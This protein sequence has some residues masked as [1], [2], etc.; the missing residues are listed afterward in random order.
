M[1]PDDFLRE[2]ADGK[3]SRGLLPLE[4]PAGSDDCADVNDMDESNGDSI[5]GDGNDPRLR[6]AVGAIPGLVTPG[7]AGSPSYPFGVV[8][9]DV[10]EGESV[11]G[12]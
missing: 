9:P 1:M 6:A 10:L 2:S 4:D 12:V 5:P 3:N 8:R 11:A 7:P